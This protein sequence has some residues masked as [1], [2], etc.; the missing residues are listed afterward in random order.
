MTDTKFVGSYNNTKNL[1]YDNALPVARKYF[2]IHF[3]KISDDEKTRL[4]KSIELT[5]M[6]RYWDRMVPY[7]I[8]IDKSLERLKFFPMLINSFSTSYE[9][10]GFSRVEQAYYH[11][12]NYFAETYIFR[13]R[14]KLFLDI[15][16]KEATRVQYKTQDIKLI[17]DLKK[18]MLDK[19]EPLIE[20]RG[21]HTH[22]TRYVDGTTEKLHSITN[23]LSMSQGKVSAKDLTIYSLIQKLELKKYRTRWK[24]IIQTNNIAMEK[25]LDSIFYMINLEKIIINIASLQ[26]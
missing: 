7:F 22:E 2:E 10:N 24:E 11:V 4:M 16:K 19:L 17:G 5:P 13:E 18:I 3:K 14:F 26:K 21:A 15:L 23:I 12:E 20:I 9:K 1:V 8:E 25:I 6:E